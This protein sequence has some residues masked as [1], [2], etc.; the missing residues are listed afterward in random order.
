MPARYLA[1]E[2]LQKD[3][4]RPAPVYARIPAEQHTELIAALHGPWRTTTRMVIVVLS[5]AGW[6]ASEI[7]DLLHYDRPPSAAGLPAT[8]RKAWPGSPTGPAADDPVQA[9]A[10][11]A[12][13]KSDPD[14]GGRDGWFCSRRGGVRGVGC[15][16][17]M[18]GRGLAEWVSVLARDGWS[19]LGGS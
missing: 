5:A 19:P 3:R 6:S 12:T 18:A 14:R 9:A 8:N 2:G 15:G 16:R 11:S 1:S 17:R 13:A 7:A 4:Q 10:D